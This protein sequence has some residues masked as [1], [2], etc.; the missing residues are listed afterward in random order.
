MRDGPHCSL[1]LSRG[2]KRVAKRLDNDNYSF[3]EVC[4]AW[5]QALREDWQSDGVPD[6]WRRLLAIAQRSQPDILPLPTQLDTLRHQADGHSI[7]TKLL[8]RAYD[9]REAPW[10]YE[11]CVGIVREVLFEVSDRRRNQIVAHYRCEASP[12]AGRIEGRLAE[13][14][15]EHEQ[16]VNELAKELATGKG[17]RAAPSRKNGLDDGVPV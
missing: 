5:C 15:V 3:V 13:R 12:H 7:R 4:D 8:E 17:K 6:F 11:V 10:H 9:L 1:P 14:W 2:W 16:N